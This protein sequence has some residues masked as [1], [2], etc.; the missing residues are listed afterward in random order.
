MTARTVD[1]L[2]S[3][4]SAGHPQALRRTLSFA[5]M[6][7]YSLIFMCVISVFGIFGSVFQAS[8][9]M[10]VSAY[11]VGMV[12]MMVT[13]SSYGLLVQAYPEAGSVYA[14]AGRVIAPSVGF[15][16]GWV[17]LLDYINVPGLLSVIAAASMTAVWPAV[18]MSAWI[19]RFVVLNT[20]INLLGI[21]MTRL[22][23]KVFLIGSLFILAVYLL[24]GVLALADGK[25]RGF[26]WD[27]VFASGQFRLGVVL[28]GAS[29]AGLSFLGFDALSTLA[30][31][32][33]EGARQVSR[34]MVAG[35]GLI[36]LLFI[37]QA[38]VGALLVTDPATLIADGD[39]A[40]TVVYETARVAAGPWLQ[41]AAAIAVGLA[42][43]LA[44]NMVA[45][46]ATSRLVYA[47]ARDG[48]LPRRLAKI[49]VSR[50]V[51]TNAILLI[52][53]ISLGL[54]LYMASRDDGITLMASL[55]NFGALLSFLVV[56]VCVLGQKLRG[57]KLAG[58]WFRVWVL[59]PVGIVSL[60]AII[61]NT[62]ALAQTVGVVWLGVGVLILIV[63]VASGRTP[64]L[65]GM[66]PGADTSTALAGHRG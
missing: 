32:A 66:E 20:I 31:D 37:A 29:V 40:G 65:A 39:P 1:N 44:N 5:D 2:G 38:L 30:E 54:G 22:M 3:P 16:A 9:G 18:S 53:A 59:P 49:S 23:N 47:M 55:V 62:N 57:R 33:K 34:A 17:I 7:I 45:Q 63:L 64:R 27:P 42:W 51:P 12:V 21:R 15:L 43:G 52:A 10:V 46:V 8:G 35:L 26:S 13:A 60:A 28:S 19:V 58:G 4:S 25:G 56:H 50:A 61:W 11:V 24:A 14:Y 6:V 41:T 48:Q 36:G